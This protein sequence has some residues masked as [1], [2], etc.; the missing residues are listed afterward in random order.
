MDISCRRIGRRLEIAPR[1]RAGSSL[2]VLALGPGGLGLFSS[3]LHAASCASS[4]LLVI[5]QHLSKTYQ[6]QRW[7]QSLR[8]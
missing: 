8:R 1:A 7:R 3:V 4:A 5:Q 2:T 6:L